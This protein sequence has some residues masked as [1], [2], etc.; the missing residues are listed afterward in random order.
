MGIRWS[1][2]RHGE[3]VEQA[4][5]R[6]RRINARRRAKNGQAPIDATEIDKDSEVEIE[7]S[8]A[9]APVFEGEEDEFMAEG[10][11]GMGVGSDEESGDKAAEDSN[12]DMADAVGREDGDSGDESV[13]SAQPHPDD[14]AGNSSDEE[15]EEDSGAGSQRRF[16]RA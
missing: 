10:G 1:Q 8:N 6:Y 12:E 15:E 14:I 13:E 16:L 4:Q 2:D 3:E 11:F 5:H 7:A 9:E